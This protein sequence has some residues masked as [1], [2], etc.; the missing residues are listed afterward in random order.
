MDR[1]THRQLLAHPE[2]TVTPPLALPL[3]QSEGR[4]AQANFLRLTAETVA[5]AVVW[6][7][8]MAGGAGSAL[9]RG[10]HGWWDQQLTQH[11]SPRAPHT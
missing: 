6:S 3:S 11:Y 10:S 5:G 7:P 4:N 1:S 8:W 9:Q 2:V